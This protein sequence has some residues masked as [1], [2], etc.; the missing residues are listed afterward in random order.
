MAGREVFSWSALLATTIVALA[1]C[2]QAPVVEAKHW[3]EVGALE[4]GA[5]RFV[6][7]DA[8]SAK[9]GAVYQDAVQRACAGNCAQLGFFLAGDRQPPTRISGSTWMSAGGWGAYSP[10]AVYTNADGGIFTTWDCDRAGE[11]AAPASA[12]CGEGAEEQHSAVLRIASREGW[13][14]ACGYP[15]TDGQKVVE[16]FAATL[17]SGRGAQL[18][19][20]YRQMYSSSLGGPDDPAACGYLKENIEGKNLEARRLL[21]ASERLSQ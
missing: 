9:D 3:R 12:L 13:F 4:N 16:S 5:I 14:H 20:A 8:A 18:L 10:L 15:Q 17:P 21:M 2:G 7:V 19:E 6:E 11:E 1:G